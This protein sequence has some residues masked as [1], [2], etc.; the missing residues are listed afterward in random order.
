MAA[1]VQ[2]SYSS[3][4][5]LCGLIP[6]NFHIVV[7]MQK[8]SVFYS[9]F[10]S[11][12]WLIPIL[13]EIYNTLLFRRRSPD[14]ESINPRLAAWARIRYSYCIQARAALYRFSVALQKWKFDS[15]KQIVLPVGASGPHGERSHLRITS[16]CC[17]DQ[18]PIFSWL[19][20]LSA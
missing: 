15:S 17:S 2:N 6:I 20:D 11:L 3:T 7:L 14:Q 13:V 16:L 10:I 4:E 18:I 1:G 19:P 5:K 8:S 12:I 9:A